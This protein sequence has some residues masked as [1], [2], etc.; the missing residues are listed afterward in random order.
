M[1]HRSYE[2]PSD[3]EEED[4]DD[5]DDV[6]GMALQARTSEIMSNFRDYLSEIE[7]QSNHQHDGSD[8]SGNT[9]DGGS[10]SEYDAYDSLNSNG[11]NQSNNSSGS[12]LS[13]EWKYNS[14]GSPEVPSGGVH[15][16]LSGIRG[17][18]DNRSSYG[19]DGMRKRYTH[20]LFRSRRF[21]RGVLGA[22]GAVAALSLIVSVSVIK[23]R[24]KMGATL[25]DWEEELKESEVESVASPV[26]GSTASGFD[27]TTSSV[28]ILP[29]SEMMGLPSVTVNANDQKQKQQ[30]GP[31]I[32]EQDMHV[33]PPSQAED[34]FESVPSPPQQ[35]QQ[36]LD[37]AQ[38]IDTDVVIEE[39]PESSSQTS[40]I[41]IGG[42]TGEQ[43]AHAFNDVHE[44]FQPKWYD[45]SSGW[46][47]QTYTDALAFCSSQESAIP[48]P[49]E[50]YC[51]LGALSPPSGGYKS[52]GDISWA[53]IMDAPNAWVQVSTHNSCVEYSSI[54]T[55]PPSWGIAGDN[56]EETGHIMCC[57]EPDV[58]IAIAMSLIKPV[59][60]STPSSTTISNHEQQVMDRLKP[61][62]YGRKQGYRGTTHDDAADFCK[63][64]GD[65]HLC[66]I[67]AYCPDGLE[68]EE[69]P[70]YLNRGMF[71]GEQWAPIAS[72][73][74]GDDEWVQIGSIDGELKGG[75]CS[76]H[77]QLHGKPPLWGVDGSHPELKENVLCCVNPMQMLKETSFV[78][79]LN[80]IWLDEHHG[81]N[82]GS[83]E[84]AN[85][86]CQELDNRKLCPYSAY[87]PNGP[88]Q[89]ALGG[90]NSDFNAEEEMQWAPVYGEQ[91]HW[92]L[93]NQKYGNSSTTCMDHM[94]L[95]GH[96]PDW[97]T[98]GE[99][100]IMKKHI[101]C[102][103]F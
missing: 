44:I 38:V 90:H 43:I 102:C 78:K 27:G 52:S 20:P 50:A 10:S 75:K 85:K 51:P 40:Q 56:E 9:S 24:S 97:G 36:P 42:L 83:H 95:E 81:W 47:G 87:C 80:P 79:D 89:Q 82:G 35:E 17:S 46:T 7:A 30:E 18:Y 59:E 49:Y 88:G 68:D 58:E 14:D 72:T 99:A 25:P 64:V 53:P 12:N 73:E 8:R 41:L 91:S 70:L 86:F 63:N 57:N 101:M 5:D 77:R 71:S 26:V 96:S 92:V 21:K 74:G 34:D 55:S 6:P 60:S 69:S 66:P 45:R 103:D 93:L 28:P 65:M 31:Q 37:N 2:D 32:D 39:V 48:C 54:H 76:T 98:S 19:G 15:D 29:H 84:D 62:W 67:E 61:V 11:S 94:E 1:I 3:S 13:R 16:N 100:A 22:L 33:P 4:D 23:G